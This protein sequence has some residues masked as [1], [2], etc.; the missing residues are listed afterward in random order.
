MSERVQWITHKGKR[1]LFSDYSGLAGDEYIAA[2]E[3]TE[4]EIIQ[5]PAGSTLLTLVDLTDST[6]SSAAVK[7][8]QELEVA[9]KQRGVRTFVATVGLVGMKAVLIQFVRKDVHAV[10]SVEEGKDWLAAQ[11]DKK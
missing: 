8:G 4:R 3:A 11:S 6:V 2:L 5:H 1:I 10:A 7:R 9:R